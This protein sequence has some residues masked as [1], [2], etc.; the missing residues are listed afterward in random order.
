MRAPLTRN[1]TSA[2]AAVKPVGSSISSSFVAAV[3]MG[4]GL[5]LLL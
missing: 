3:L 2:A 4:F 5:I 1:R